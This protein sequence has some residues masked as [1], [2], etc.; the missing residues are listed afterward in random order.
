MKQL[1][2]LFILC[3]FS[4]TNAQDEKVLRSI[5]DKALTES[6]AYENLRILCKDIGP[7]LSGSKEADSA[8]VWGERILSALNLDTVYL[9]E[10]MVPHWERGR[11]EKAYFYNEKGKNSIDICALGGSV[12][13]RHE[14]VY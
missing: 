2:T 6:E 5:F 1:L 4:T 14:S 10:I 12:F 13:Y 7:R 11:K 3:I 8:V 9:Q